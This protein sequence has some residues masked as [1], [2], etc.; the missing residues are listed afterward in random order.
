MVAIRPN[1]CAPGTVS[2]PVLDRGAVVAVER[3][4]FDSYVLSSGAGPASPADTNQ[5]T[6]ME[7]NFA[8]F[9]GLAVDLWVG[10]L[11]P[12]DT[13]FDQFLDANP[14]AFRALGE[15]GEPGLVPGQL[16]CTSSTQRDCFR[17][18][19]NFKRDPGVQAT[20]NA[21]GEGGAGSVSIAAGGTRVAGTTDPLLGL[22]IFFASNLSLKNPNFRTARCG[23]CHAVPTLT[24][25][26]VAFTSKVNLRDFVAEF[27]PGQPGNETIIEP[28]GRL[29]TISGFLL[30][31]ELAEN[32]QD[33]VERRIAN[34]SIVPCPTDGLAYPGGS[35]P[36][37]EAGP[38]YGHCGGAA[39]AFFD[40][41]V[42]NLGVRPI[43]EDSGRGGTDAF[44]WPLSL[45]A[46]MMKNLGGVG[47]E[48]GQ[49][50]PNFD[51]AD[52][53]G[54][55]GLFEETAQDQQVN[56][57][58]EGDPISPQLPAYLARWANQI[59]VGDSMPE[60]DEV[61]GG[62]NTLTNI[63]ML[64]GFLDTLGPFNPAGILN[65][66][67][68][69]GEGALMGTWPVVNRVG[70]EGSF[71]APQLRNVELTGPYFHNGGKLTLRQVVDFYVRGGDFPMTNAAHRDFNMVNMNLEVQSNLTEE[72]KVA[73]VDFLLELTDERNRFDRAPFDHPQV[74]VPVDGRA[75]E[76]TLGRAA[77]LA[78]PMF[79][80]VP[81]VG[82]AGQATPEPTFLGIAGRS[83]GLNGQPIQRLVG[84][85][86]S[87][88]PGATSHYCH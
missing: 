13:P 87:C 25:H 82:A 65:E 59:N 81:A 83:P 57:G 86:A 3:D 33:A 19:G 46:L 52:P 34:Q 77:L 40:N 58:I 76:N 32:G 51:P 49:E 22:D 16:N 85:A 48:P 17:E 63:G 24:D 7:G 67:L 71:K 60:L 4:P 54:G 79:R 28:L 27:V 14:D 69:V 61:F 37:L 20:I 64:E 21:T 66:S 6:Q 12:D 56:P 84:A 29:R 68:N 42:Y 30:E 70:R 8:L 62:L 78:D 45:A 44:G 26:T 88:G 5:F 23:E 38:G 15:P 53:S 10:I 80:D 74:I 11:V 41:G 36:V 73:L 35:E 43:A 39:A 55:G 75:A 1:Q 2:V 18:V 31:S 72:E 47:F 9:W 50:L